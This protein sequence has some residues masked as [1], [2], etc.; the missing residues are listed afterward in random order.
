MRRSPRSPE[1]VSQHLSSLTSRFN[2]SLENVL[3]S[4]LL[5][6][7][8]SAMARLSFSSSLLFS[9]YCTRKRT[10][11]L[12]V[13]LGST[14]PHGQDAWIK[15][16]REAFNYVLGI[17]ALMQATRSSSLN[18]RHYKWYAAVEQS[19]FSKRQAL[20]VP[21][22]I[23]MPSCYNLDARCF[24]SFHASLVG[25]KSDPHKRCSAINADHGVMVIKWGTMLGIFSASSGQGSNICVPL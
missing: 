19:S 10:T 3:S 4:C 16:S 13:T 7:I 6:M 5:S 17:P 12:A 20:R 24:L 18:L 11:R 1:R 2:D 15:N 9:K 23:G 21:S 25:R 14:V 22:S 8:L